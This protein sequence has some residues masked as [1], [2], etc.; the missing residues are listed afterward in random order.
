MPEKDGMEQYHA[1]EKRSDLVLRSRR[2][3]KHPG[4]LHL[5]QTTPDNT[6]P[7]LEGWKPICR[8]PRVFPILLGMGL[9][10]MAV[11]PAVDP[12]LWWHLRTGQLTL[13]NHSVFR[14]DPYSFTRAG[15]PWI[16]HEWLSDVLMF[17]LY[18][19]GGWGGLIVVFAALIAAT[20]LLG[21]RRCT[22]RPFL[23]L[24]LTVWAAFASLPVWGVR[25]QVL[26]LFFASL[27]LTLHGISRSR[28][29]RLWWTVPLMLLWV[30][31]HAGYALGIA[32]L[33]L[34]LVG[35]G[36]DRAFGFAP[37]SVAVGQGRRQLGT[38]SLVLIACLAVVPLNPYGVKMY[39]YPLAT[40]QSAGMQRH[41]AEWFSPDF[42]QAR[43]L[44]LA[45]LMVATIAALALSARRLR[46]GELILLMAGTFAA[47]LSARHIAIYALIAAPILS[48]LLDGLFTGGNPGRR[49]AP[50]TAAVINLLLLVLFSAFV[51]RHLH[52][53][54][55]HQPEAE[56]SHFPSRAVSFLAGRRPPGPLFSH[57]DWGGYL[58]WRLYP[59]YRVFID[60]RA[61]VYGD[62]LMKDFA[63]ADSLSDDW[64][65][66][67]NRW[68][69]R[70]VLLP[71]DSPLVV[72]LKTSGQWRE[73]YADSQAAI[74]CR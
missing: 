59:D 24:I 52:R 18:R 34:F 63:S 69:I 57:Y 67:L 50:R 58:I 55:T 54:V 40:L 65:G 2:P 74:L 42:H 19:R 64:G 9:F 13:Q 33:V 1:G 7:A 35:E 68:K 12:D 73:I 56:A 72:A 43:Y 60:G 37:E 36:M 27:L 6:P 4:I 16:N 11:R 15:Q 66:V 38:A 62:S 17:G 25:P 8:A 61:D 48:K 45:C 53:I 70:T 28:P 47:L 31:L 30:N 41:I 10:V 49:L 46:P 21:F 44:P 39:G 22:G 3:V 20:Y 23:S 71:A 14:S 51:V 26:S 5:A 32:L 29:R